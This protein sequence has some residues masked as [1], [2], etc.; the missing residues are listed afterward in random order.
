[1][2]SRSDLRGWHLL[3]G[4]KKGIIEVK[5]GIDEAEIAEQEQRTLPLLL[6]LGGALG[7]SGN[8]CREDPH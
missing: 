1:L 8:Y 5:I 2:V 3:S 6:S 4:L 7:E